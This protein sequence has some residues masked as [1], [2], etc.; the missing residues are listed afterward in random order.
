MI[1]RF[2]LN[3]DAYHQILENEFF[4]RDYDPEFSNLE[5][6]I[7]QSKEFFDVELVAFNYFLSRNIEAYLKK[8]IQCEE[9]I[10][11]VY[12]LEEQM[13]FTIQE[14]DYRFITYL[15]LEQAPGSES[16]LDEDLINAIQDYYE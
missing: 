15:I 16:S 2:Y 6:W 5:G 7:K 11:F 9:L 4:K 12:K 10:N 8:G 14:F 3:N 1:A 13:L